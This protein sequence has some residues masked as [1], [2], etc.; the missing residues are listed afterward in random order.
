M[1]IQ[2][3]VFRLIRTIVVGRI[4]GGGEVLRTFAGRRRMRS[5][6]SK[7]VHGRREPQEASL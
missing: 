7:K 5:K 4:V 1:G 3:V 6:R 2:L